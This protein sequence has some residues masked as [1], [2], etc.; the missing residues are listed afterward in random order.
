VFSV[1][2]PFAFQ[3]LLA[4]PVWGRILGSAIIMFPL[5]FFMGMPFPLGIQALTCQPRGAIAWAWGMNAL[6]TVIGGVACG[7][8][9]IVFGFQATLVIGLA[10]YAVALLLIGFL[11]SRAS[12]AAARAP[13]LS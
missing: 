11:L 1:S 7:V 12:V 3:G 4:M 8:L 9:S 6:F 5:G 10:I 13:V 2:Y